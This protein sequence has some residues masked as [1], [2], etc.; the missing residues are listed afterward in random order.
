[1]RYRLWYVV[2]ILSGVM[3]IVLGSFFELRRVW[4]V[5]FV[6]GCGNVCFVL[7]MV[8]VVMFV[9]FGFLVCLDGLKF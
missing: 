4:I 5:L 3:D 6:I 7:F 2:V 9:G 1:M 8:D